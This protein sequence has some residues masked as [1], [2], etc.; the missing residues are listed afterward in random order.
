[1]KGHRR[2]HGHKSKKDEQGRKDT[3]IRLLDKHALL[4]YVRRENERTAK[5]RAKALKHSISM[6]TLEGMI[7]PH[8]PVVLQETFA[9]TRSASE[10]ALQHLQKQRRRD[11]KKELRQKKAR[12]PR[13]GKIN[14]NSIFDRYTKEGFFGRLSIIEG[15]PR[16]QKKPSAAWY[17]KENKYIKRLVEYPS[18]N[19]L[20]M[21]VDE[22][23]NFCS[24]FFDRAG[25][26]MGPDEDDLYFIFQACKSNPRNSCVLKRDVVHIFKT[27]SARE[28]FSKLCPLLRPLF[29]PAK[30]SFTTRTRFGHDFPPSPLTRRAIGNAQFSMS[31]SVRHL[32]SM[33]IG[34]NAKTISECARKQ[35]MLSAMHELQHKVK[36]LQTIDRSLI[37]DPVR[38]RG[39]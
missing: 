35:G 17:E 37:L 19:S 12:L 1:M 2:S 18:K 34:Y 24:P 32:K 3:A 11:E 30:I 9:L 8:D 28:R 10:R 26:P 23:L 7:D 31:Q 39:E 36:E 38:V 27:Q 4:K 13:I 25:V 5:K 14:H 22:W 15:E 21:R 16:F 33:S 29:R 20:T 6:P